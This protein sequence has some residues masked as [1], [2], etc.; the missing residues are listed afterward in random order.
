[1]IQI[2]QQARHWIRDASSVVVLTGAGISA[3]SGIPTFR[4]SEEAPEHAIRRARGLRVRR[5]EDDPECSRAP[6]TARSAFS[7]QPYQL[8]K[9]RECNRTTQ[10]KSSPRGY[11]PASA[12][13]E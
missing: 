12:A 10:N 1:M 2:M 7:K 9:T 6:R 13:T 11:I 8:L 5:H 4:Q 3:E